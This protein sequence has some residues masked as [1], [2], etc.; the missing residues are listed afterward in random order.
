[1]V[2][3]VWYVGQMDY[4]VVDVI[5]IHTNIHTDI[6]TYIRTYI[7]LPLSSIGFLMMFNV[8]GLLFANDVAAHFYFFH[9][10][11]FFRSALEI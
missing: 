6:H 9:L 10:I 2:C 4:L 8:C 11:L 1:M 3:G 5:Y 7:T